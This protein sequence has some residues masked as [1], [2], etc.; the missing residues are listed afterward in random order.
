MINPKIFSNC[1]MSNPDLE[2]PPELS[3]AEELAEVQAA[4][5]MSPI[6]LA[7]N[8]S[9]RWSYAM[10]LIRQARREKKAK[11]KFNKKFKILS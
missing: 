7:H 8:D 9:A 4:I 1:P 5:A 11:K 6:H 10:H 3:P 2:N